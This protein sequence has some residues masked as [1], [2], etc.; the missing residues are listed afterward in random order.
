MGLLFRDVWSPIWPNLAASAVW[1]PGV[2]WWHH[3][4]LRRHVTAEVE[5]V[6]QAMI[7]HGFEGEEPSGD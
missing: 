7:G 3:S 1:A 4:R 6:H 2:L 5:R